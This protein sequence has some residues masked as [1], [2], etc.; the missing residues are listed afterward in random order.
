MSL[1]ISIGILAGG[2]STRM[3]SDKALMQ[4]GNERFIE[5]IIKELD[6]YSEIIISAGKNTSYEELGFKTVYDE[7]TRVGPMEGIRQILKAAKEEYVFICAVDMPFVSRDIVDHILGY[8]SSDYDCYVMTHEEKIEPLCAVYRK[9]AF[10][11]IDELISEKRYRLRE[12]FSLLPT[13]YIPMEGTSLNEKVL[14]NIN[15]KEDFYEALND[16]MF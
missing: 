6:H 12:I 16:S 13:R 5:R 11:V 15:T 14:R 9:N 2:K 1:N 3:G 4:I 7:N 10:T 8:V